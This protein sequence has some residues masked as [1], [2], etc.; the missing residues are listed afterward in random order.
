MIDVF[1]S[2]N[3]ISSV[4][5]LLFV[6]GLS[7]NSDGSVRVAVLQSDARFRCNVS[8]P[9]DR[10]SECAETAVVSRTWLRRRQSLNETK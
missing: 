3:D 7:S 4:S 9:V 8:E 1:A 5:C 6:P 10:Y 2:V